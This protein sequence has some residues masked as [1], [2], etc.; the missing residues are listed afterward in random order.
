MIGDEITSEEDMKEYEEENKLKVN[1]VI[2]EFMPKGY[3]DDDFKH[4]DTDPAMLGAINRS[5]LR[6]CQKKKMGMYRWWL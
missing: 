5:V 3:Y 2:K 6:P 4:D 1:Q